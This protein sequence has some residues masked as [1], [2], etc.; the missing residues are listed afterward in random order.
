MF[1]NAITAFYWSYLSELELS[2]LVILTEVT[3]YPKHGFR[4]IYE[5]N[6]NGM[7]KISIE[8]RR[9]V[10]TASVDDIANEIL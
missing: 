6:D 1:T 7:I 8:K 10:F 3:S 4:I 5:R 9:Y 2:G